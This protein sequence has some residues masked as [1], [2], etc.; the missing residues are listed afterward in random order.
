MTTGH[1]SGPKSANKAVLA[2]AS[3]WAR[4][5]TTAQRAK[6]GSADW[7]D[8]AHDTNK[9]TRLGG[10]ARYR[11]QVSCGGKLARPAT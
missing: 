8:A 4:G 6:N 10:R 1:M 5:S 7:H 11:L 2:L 9:F 3:L